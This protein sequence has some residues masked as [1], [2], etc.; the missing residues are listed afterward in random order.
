MYNPKSKIASEF[1]CDSEIQDTMRYAR[2][3]CNNRELVDSILE[4]A[5]AC[6]GTFHALTYHKLT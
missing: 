6:K 4:K 5:R 1:I 2:E 3:N